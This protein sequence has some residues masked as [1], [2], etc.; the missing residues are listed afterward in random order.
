MRKW[1]NLAAPDDPTAWDDVL[2]MWPTSRG[3]YEVADF[4]TTTGGTLTAT[5]ESTTTLISSWALRAITDQ[6]VFLIGNSIWEF[7]VGVLTD[8][9]GALSKPIASTVANMTMYGDIAI[10]ARGTAAT[11][12]R[13]TASGGAFAAL[14]GAPNARFAVVQSNALVLLNTGTSVDGWAASDVGDYT[15]WS[16][17]EYASGRI[18][19][20]NGPITDAVPFG[21]DIIVFKETAIFRMTYVGGTV[22]WQVQK[23]F[24]GIGAQGVGRMKP[25]LACG[26]L[27]FFRAPIGGDIGPSR[28]RYYLFDGVSPPR[29]VNPETQLSSNSGAVGES[30]ACPVA[31]DPVERRVM[32][33]YE[34]DTI[35]PYFYSIEAD[36]WGKGPTFTA[37][38]RNTVMRGDYSALALVSDKSS[39]R[40]YF[41]GGTDLI[42]LS[43]PVSPGGSTASPSSPASPYVISHF[44]GQPDRKTDWTRLYPLLRRKTDASAGAPATTCAVNLYRERY[45]TSADVASTKVGVIDPKR[46]RFN[47]Q[48]SDNYVQFA[49]TFK[50]VDVEIDDIL[51]EGSLRGR[52]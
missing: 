1:K 25:A 45:A 48:A 21:N 51:V 9:S 34:D 11:T 5:A 50:D 8:V 30:Y 23:I 35:G 20:S 16:T 32:L 44:Y 46:Y 41:R 2:M 29:L 6:R 15:N 47:F 12:I 28:E 38:S 3:T 14:A 24:E 13:Q 42:I 37:S 40:S 22:K 31:Y 27:I 26:D 7:P 10:V 52:E 33:A 19:E 39:L 17:G 18:L 43:G 4:Y 49:L 36:A